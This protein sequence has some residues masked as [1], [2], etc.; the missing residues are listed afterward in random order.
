MR[1]SA[2]ALLALSLVLVNPG[3]AHGAPKPTTP[4]VGD[5]FLY[6]PAEVELLSIKKSPV[7]CKKLH[8]V[9]IYRVIASQFRKDPNLEPPVNIF[10]RVSPICEAGIRS[11]KYFSGWVAKVPTKSEWKSGARWLRCE[12]FVAQTESETVTYKSWKGK[13]LDIK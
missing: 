13:K 3:L 8:N 6:A 9:E 11:S 1:R 5:C 12:A 4:K 2:Y 7:S 10:G